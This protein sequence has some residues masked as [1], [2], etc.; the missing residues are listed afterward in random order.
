MEYNPR[1]RWRSFLLAFALTLLLLALIMVGTVMAVQP[2]MP[3]TLQKDSANGQ[4]LSYRPND[5]DSLTAV[6]I[7]MRGSEPV[8]FVLVRF[9]PQYG[10]VPLTMLPPQTLVPLDG[11]NLTLV[12]AFETGGS[13]AVKAALSE[14]LGVMVDRYA[15]VDGDAFQRIVEKTGSVEFELPEDVSYRR[16]GYSI[17]LAAGS[18]RLDA[19]DMFDLF[20]YPAFRRD[21]EARCGLLGRMLAAWINQNLDA[22]GEERSSSLFKLTVNSA[23]RKLEALGMVYLEMSGSKHK[24]V[25]FTEQGR[26]LADRTAGRVMEAEDQ[27]FASWTKEE[28]ETYLGLTEAFARA[29]KEKAEEMEGHA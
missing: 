11:K 24:T 6:V 28:V 5:S 26:A 22:A 4:Q 16:D 7:G 19:R 8:D 12:Q 25:C 23:L 20:A 3:N 2:S 14:R 10:Q 18:R 15:R 9:N 27:I 17:N 1:E 21:Q 29:L 13:R